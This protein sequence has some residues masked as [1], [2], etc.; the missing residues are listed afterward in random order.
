[1]KAIGLDL[2]CETISTAL[3]DL[4]SGRI[5]KVLSCPNNT[6][7]PRKKKWESLMRA[8]SVERCAREMID[9][10]LPDGG[11]AAIGISGPTRGMLYLDADGKALGTA[12][13]AGDKRGEQLFRGATTFAEEFSAVT[14]HRSG[15][16]DGLVQLFYDLIYRRVPEGAAAI[17]TIGDYVGMALC[18]NKE[19]RLHASAAAG[20]GVFEL[21][22]G[23]FD[24]ANLI[25]ANTDLN[26]LP[27]VVFGEELLGSYSGVPVCCAVGDVQ[28]RVFACDNGRSDA[29]VQIGTETYIAALGDAVIR[30]TD[31]LICRPYVGGRYL[32]IGT[33]RVGG[34]NYEALRLFFSRTAEML[35]A[36]Q[37]DTLYRQMD[38]Q[39]HAVYNSTGTGFQPRLTDRPASPGELCLQVLEDICL[40]LYAESR[41]MLPP[42]LSGGTLTATGA[43]V[44]NSPL[45]R[46]LLTECFGMHIVV[47]PPR[48]EAA[49][50]AALIAAVTAGKLG[51][52]Q[53]QDF[54]F[55]RRK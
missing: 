17:C 18:G 51:A 33:P 26:L 23:R 39:A 1:M 35:G 54:V 2:G 47:P 46:N 12:R 44:R 27:P 8:E 16:E 43:A 49:Y 50:G 25:N 41:R 36:P 6:A 3:V 19:P 5:L 13:T 20:L 31:A 52:Q 32:T 7:A 28:A 55:P 40:A 9:T 34:K 24:Y 11:V 42:V 29:V 10:L 4:S 38:E 30:Y 14:G 53:A 37:T 15:V 21:S 22:K 48:S 45:L